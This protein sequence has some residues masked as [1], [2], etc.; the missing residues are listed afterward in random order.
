MP[1]SL[2]K[3]EALIVE[4]NDLPRN[5]MYKFGTTI[6]PWQNNLF[7]VGSNYE[8]NFTN[9]SPTDNFKLKTQQTLKQILKLPFKT[10][11]HLSAV[12]PANIERRPFVGFHPKYKNIGVF[13]GM[14]TKGCS[15]TPYFA[16]E[17]VQHLLYNTPINKEVDIKRFEKVLSR[18]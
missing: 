7:W 6:V 9:D 16:N 14:G 15:L 17:F 1:Y 18:N 2:V 3:G 5:Q 11:Y 13:N 12:R 4:I 10:H 8:W